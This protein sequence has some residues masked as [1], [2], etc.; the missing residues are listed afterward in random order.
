MPDGRKPPTTVAFLLLREFSMLTVVCGV[1]PLRAANTLTGRRI[2]DWRF[3]SNDGAPLSASNGMIVNVAGGVS[4][5]AKD[6]DSIDFCSS[7]PG[8][9]PIRRTGR[10][11]TRLC[12]IARGP[13]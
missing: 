6:L 10:D 4:D 13:R 9:T 3:Y 12:T 7:A 2:Y 5:I 1:E 11:C 8:S